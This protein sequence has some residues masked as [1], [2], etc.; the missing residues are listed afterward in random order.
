MRF[1]YQVPP[2]P[3][4]RIA[5]AAPLALPSPT[6]TTAIQKIALNRLSLAP[7]SRR[8]MSCRSISALADRIYQ[9]GQLQSLMVVPTEDSRYYVVAG[10][11]RFAALQLLA[12]DKR[13]SQTF[14][15]PCR[16][17]DGRATSQAKIVV[18]SA[19]FAL[20]PAADERRRRFLD[21]RNHC[22]GLLTGSEF[23]ARQCFNGAE[24]P[25]LSRGEGKHTLR[26][27]TSPTARLANMTPTPEP[28]LTPAS[29]WDRT[30]LSDSR[31]WAI[32]SS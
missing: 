10:D 19:L 1:Q 18:D 27:E 24:P 5:E 12:G 22:P 9:S 15:V 6:P 30:T 32:H 31:G 4:E 13:I 3:A 2:A 17:I 23:A 26:G 21:L 7:G 16:V 8:K 20:G 14:L 29:S 11:R 25:R 28:R